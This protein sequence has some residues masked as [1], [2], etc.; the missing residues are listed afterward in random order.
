VLTLSLYAGVNVE[1]LGCAQS[2]QYQQIVG[3]GN[4]KCTAEDE[5][6]VVV[7]EG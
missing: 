1:L 4:V 2:S 5:N 7:R 6:S 3:G